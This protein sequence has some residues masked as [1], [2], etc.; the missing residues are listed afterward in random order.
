M[1]TRVSQVLA[2]LTAIALIAVGV[3]LVIPEAGASPTTIG[4]GDAG[5]VTVGRSGDTLS[6]LEI[7]PSIGWTSSVGSAAGQN[8]DVELTDGERIIRLTVELARGALQAQISE[9]LVDQPDDVETQ[10]APIDGQEDPTTTTE[11]ETTTSG[12][13]TT[14]SAGDPATTTTVR[15]VTTTTRAPTPPPTNAA[16]TTTVQAATTTT[17]AVEPEV[18]NVTTTTAAPAT[19]A[20]T[21]PV[22]AAPATTTHQAPQGAGTVTLSWTGS[23]VSASAAANAGWSVQVASSGGD[24]AAVVF[25]SDTSQVLVYGYLVGSERVVEMS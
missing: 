25:F 7:L 6:F 21:A 3:F 16:T 12:D 15:A 5:V 14:T 1:K 24:V 13:S 18:F 20:T 8:I 4:V 19:T 23:T 10:D 11:A 9:F 17:C 22:I 2:A